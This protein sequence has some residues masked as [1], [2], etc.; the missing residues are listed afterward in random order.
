MRCLSLAIW[1]KKVSRF[2]RMSCCYCYCCWCCTSYTYLYMADG[3]KGRNFVEKV[4][5]F[6]TMV[7]KLV[8]ESIN[9]IVSLPYLF[10]VWLVCLEWKKSTSI[11]SNISI[12][13]I[14][15][16]WKIQ[17]S[18]EFILFDNRKEFYRGA[19]GKILINYHKYFIE[20]LSLATFITKINNHF[21]WITDYI[22]GQLFNVEI[23]SSL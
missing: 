11:R 2:C 5:Y 7:W 9:V 6:S 18:I 19:N 20:V 17:E 14:F 13:F 8:F 3:L 12:E 22:Y 23:R 10:V 1:M 15:E 21:R 16:T 4:E